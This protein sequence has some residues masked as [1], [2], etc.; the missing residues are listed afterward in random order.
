M[1]KWLCTLAR[2]IFHRLFGGATRRL[3]PVVF[4]K[5]SHTDTPP[6]VA[7]VMVDIVYVVAPKGVPKWTMLRCPCGCGEV[8]TL[9]LQPTHEPRWTFDAATSGRA[10]LYPSIWR[11]TGCHSHFWLKDGRVFWA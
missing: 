2:W 4:H 8:I 10:S 6:Q 7:Q 1:F 9:S 5:V 11:T 3:P